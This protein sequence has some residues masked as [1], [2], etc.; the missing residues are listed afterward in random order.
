MSAVNSVPMKYAPSTCR[1][2]LAA[3]R[4]AVL[5]DQR[6]DAQAP[7]VEGLRLH[8]VEAP[9]VVAGEWPQPFARAVVQP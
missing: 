4:P 6:Q 3:A 1:R 2:A 8:E 9:D 5:I 7:A